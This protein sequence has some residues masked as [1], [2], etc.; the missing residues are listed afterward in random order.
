[1]EEALRAIRVPHRAARR[2]YV[3]YADDW[4]AFCATRE[5]AEAA[6][7]EAAVWLAERGLQ[8]S[9]EKTRITHLKDGFDYLGF[10]IRH[11]RAP[12]TSRDGW[13]LLI[14]PSKAAIRK[15]KAKLKAIWRKYRGQSL[16]ALLGALNPVIRGWANYYRGVV[17]K[18]VF[19]QLDNWMFR[20]CVRW[21][22]HRHPRKSW[23]W[24]RSR[25]WGRLNPSSTSTWIFGDTSTG[26]YLLSFSTTPIVRHA[27]VKG[28]AS[29]D[30]PDLGDYWEQRHQRKI[31]DLPPKWIGLARK[32][33]RRCPSCQLSLFNDE[34][35]HEYPP[36]SRANTNRARP[37]LVHSICHQSKP[38]YRQE[39]K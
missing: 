20:R 24:L 31:N 4:V 17:S 38:A 10:N 7:Q 6:R 35:L 32:Q 21:V 28:T 34:D 9:E 22:R 11:H 1:M 36:R 18:R 13:K 8:L 3:R 5:D 2:S 16:T 14:K 23:K 37:H 19:G 25:Y 29:P 15:L 30:D 12:K 26:A 39:A 33:R 27:I